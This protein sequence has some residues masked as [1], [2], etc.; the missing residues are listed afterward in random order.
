M[1]S[2]HRCL[3]ALLLQIFHVFKRRLH[4]EHLIVAMHSRAF[5]MLSLLVLVALN[6]RRDWLAPHARWLG[7]LLALL[8]GPA[9]L[10]MLAYLLIMQK[11]VY[12]QGCGMTSLK[13]GCIGICYSVLIGIGM[14]CALL[15]SLGSAQG[16]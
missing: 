14:A 3:F 4:M 7:N 8:R 5:L 1:R 9:W 16:S 12:R 10:W 2:R 11:R 13:Y 6:M 15:V